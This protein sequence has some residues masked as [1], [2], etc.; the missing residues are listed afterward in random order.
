MPSRREVI[1]SF[2]SAAVV[3]SVRTNAGAGTG[4]GAG[5][6]VADSTG[7]LAGAA[8]V[9]G[10]PGVLPSLPRSHPTVAAYTGRLWNQVDNFAWNRFQ[11]FSSSVIGPTQ[12]GPILCTCM[13]C[14]EYDFAERVIERG[15]PLYGPVCEDCW[16]RL[17]EILL[18]FLP[19][20]ELD[21]VRTEI[22]DVEAE[23]SKRTMA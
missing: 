17:D 21:K 14:L 2:V 1:K 9:A 12:S 22:A 18:S 19:G 23:L 15:P 11:N 20:A 10:V 16:P 7:G 8:E 3:G 5:A 6:A 13:L 4:A